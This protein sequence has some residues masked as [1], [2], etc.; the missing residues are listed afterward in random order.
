VA[1]PYAPNAEAHVFP[2]EERIVSAATALVRSAA[3]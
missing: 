1:M 2:S 3:A